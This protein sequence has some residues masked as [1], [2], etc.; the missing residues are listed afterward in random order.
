MDGQDFQ[1]LGSLPP[2]QRSLVPVCVVQLD[3]E[4]DPH[5]RLWKQFC[6][7]AV[8]VFLLLALVRRFRLRFIELRQQ[9][10]YWQ[11]LHQ[12]A[13]QREADLKQEVLSLQAQIRALE[14][15]LYGRKSETASRYFIAG[16]DAFICWPPSP[17]ARL[18][19]I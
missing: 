1:S 12:R 8:L 5:A 3:A 19:F 6:K 11:A 10:N 13:V 14:R 16:T 2:E 18:V 9:A 7:L 17:S 4:P 15:R